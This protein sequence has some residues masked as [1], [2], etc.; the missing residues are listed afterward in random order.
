[1]A[2]RRLIHLWIKCEVHISLPPIVPLLACPPFL[3]SPPL[4]PSVLPPVPHCEL[5]EGFLLRLVWSPAGS[6]APACHCLHPSGRTV[7]RGVQGGK[8]IK[9]VRRIT[10]DSMIY[11][12]A[13]EM[14]LQMI[15]V[16]MFLCFGAFGRT[17]HITIGSLLVRNIANRGLD[18]IVLD[19]WGTTSTAI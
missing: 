3:P 4:P 5:R 15:F 8:R 7:F 11:V 18:L 6:A 1:M 10:G 13:V 12:Q 2:A 14:Q 9:G 19:P 16:C 17:L